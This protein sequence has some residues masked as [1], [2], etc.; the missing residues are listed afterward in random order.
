[1]H[2]VLLA[3]ATARSRRDRIAGLRTSVLLRCQCLPVARARGGV[4][5]YLSAHLILLHHQAAQRASSPCAPYTRVIHKKDASVRT[6]KGVLIKVRKATDGE[7]AVEAAG[8]QR[9]VVAPIVAAADLLLGADGKS[10]DPEFDAWLT[11][12]AASGPGLFVL[13]AETGA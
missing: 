7:A 11:E 3:V 10:A 4:E 9:G 1:M 12:Q 5:M 8:G 2:Q 6:L 13:S